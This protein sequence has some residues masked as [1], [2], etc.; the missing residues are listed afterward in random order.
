MLPEGGGCHYS[1]LRATLENAGGQGPNLDHLPL[2]NSSWEYPGPP[3]LAS[4]LHQET[5]A[6]YPERNMLIWKRDEMQRAATLRT[7][8]G[9]FVAHSVGLF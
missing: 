3:F 6:V 9:P 7:A 1:G 8:R 4:V 2:L 5:L